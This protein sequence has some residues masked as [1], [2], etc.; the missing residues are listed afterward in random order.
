[1][2]LANNDILC[3]FI[4]KQLKNVA[5]DKKLCYTDLK[6]LCKYITASIF[7]ENNCSLWNGYVTNEKNYLKGIYINFYFRGKKVALHR[8]LYTN[9]RFRKWG[10]IIFE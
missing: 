8:L 5:S 7:D 6:R 3:E 1:M 4:N 9:F 2:V 10:G